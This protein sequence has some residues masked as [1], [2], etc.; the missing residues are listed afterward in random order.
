M[1]E[2]E[3]RLHRAEASFDPQKPLDWLNA[4]VTSH[5]CPKPNLTYNRDTSPKYLVDVGFERQRPCIARVVLSSTVPEHELKYAAVSHVWGEL[6]E[7]EKALRTTTARNRTARLEGTPLV[8]FPNH[9]QAV[10][11]MCRR[12][13]I[14]YLW[15]DSLCIVQGPEGDWQEESKRMAGIYGSAYVTI[16]LN[17]EEDFFETSLHPEFKASLPPPDWARQYEETKGLIWWAMQFR[18]MDLEGG[19]VGKRAWCLQERHLSPRLIHLIDRGHM[20]WECCEISATSVSPRA[21]SFCNAREASKMSQSKQKSAMHRR[22]IDIPDDRRQE[23]RIHYWHSILRQYK[24]RSIRVDTDNLAGITGIAER[25]HEWTGYEYLSGLWREDLPRGLLWMRSADY[26]TLPE[27]RSWS[28]FPQ[29]QAPSWSWSSVRGPTQLI[30]YNAN[31]DEPMEVKP[32]SS[33][34]TWTS[35]V[36]DIQTEINQESPLSPVAEGSS[37]T[38][39]GC[40]GQLLVTGQ[41]NTVKREFLPSFSGIIFKSAE[42]SDETCGYI[43]FDIPSDSATCQA[44]WCLLIAASPRIDSQYLALALQ[45]GDTSP[46]PHLQKPDAEATQPSR[47]WSTYRRVGIMYVDCPRGR[48]LEEIFGPPQRI[49]IF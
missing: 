12:L 1:D 22:L 3:M 10:S 6:S 25:V 34:R 15:I 23:I 43:V 17:T 18:K 47:T 14:R 38:M 16:S 27:Q 13:G 20:L 42:S 21:F 48:H 7:Q 29:Y 44:V 24:K 46:E 33:I 37:I 41:T 39:T 2:H 26:D 30:E 32:V 4:C 36:Y 28:R 9:Y 31:V 11:L 19:P 8:Q 40:V 45:K 49:R 35:V 5:P